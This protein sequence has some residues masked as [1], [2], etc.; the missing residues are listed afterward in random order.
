MSSGH[1]FLPK[2]SLPRLP[3]FPAGQTL[4]WLDHTEDSR[5]SYRRRGGHPVYGEHDITYSFNSLG[6]RSVE[7][8]VRADI[9]IL[10]VGCSY[11]LGVGLPQQDLFH[12]LFAARLGHATT[13]SIAAFNLSAPGASNDYISRMLQLA[14][15]LL[16]PTL[17]LVNFTHKTRRE[18]ASIE[19]ELLTYVPRYRP[20]SPV[21]RNIYKHLAAL[22][23]PSDDD[24]NLFRNYKA[25]EALLTTRAWM[26]SSIHST[27]FEGI[28]EH[29]ARAHYVGS[30]PQADRAR[31]GCHPGPKSHQKL[32]D[33]YWERFVANRFVLN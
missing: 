4:E 19:G 7:F 1:F 32:A 16:D 24:L 17:V 10:A 22:T 8:H 25:I 14:V 6:Y 12:E 5:E 9:R 13:K 28:E 31:D 21:V 15:P 3:F 11:V 27:E 23:S 20:E 18:Y 2:H 30:M 33:A 29:V 26:F